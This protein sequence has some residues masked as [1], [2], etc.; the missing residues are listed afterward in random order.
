[1]LCMSTGNLIVLSLFLAI[2][3]G[4]FGNSILETPEQVRKREEEAK[5]RAEEV[6][7]I[8]LIRLHCRTLLCTAN[9]RDALLP[10]EGK[11]C[12]LR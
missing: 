3:L 12:V 2:L 9:G 5:R 10:V 7:L 1:M 8:D 11:M 4:N 6:C